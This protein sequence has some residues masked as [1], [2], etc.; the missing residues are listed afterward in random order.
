LNT[1]VY[2]LGGHAAFA[3]AGC[4]AA[5]FNREA[6]RPRLA[7]ANA[8]AQVCARRNALA[9]SNAPEAFNPERWMICVRPEKPHRFLDQGQ[10]G[11]A[12]KQRPTWEM[13]LEPDRPR[14]DQDVGHK[15]VTPTEL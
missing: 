9:E 1:A 5:H 7:L 4:E 12:R 6:K 15:L 10:H 8:H 2:R 11:Y 3:G 13:S 14:Q